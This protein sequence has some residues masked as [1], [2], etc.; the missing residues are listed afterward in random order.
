VRHADVIYVIEGG[1]IV[2]AGTHDE[3]VAK[4]HQYAAL[5]RIQTGEHLS[6]ERGGAE[7]TSA[8]HPAPIGIA[9]HA[10]AARLAVSRKLN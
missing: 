8:E 5:W 10:A 7:R 4:G 2:E 9:S 6:S 1:R 3:L